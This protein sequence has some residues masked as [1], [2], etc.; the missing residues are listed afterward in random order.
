MDL[1]ALVKHTWVSCKLSA[2]YSLHNFQMFSPLHGKYMAGSA[3]QRV[4]ASRIASIV[5]AQT[6]ATIKCGSKGCTA[7]CHPL[8]CRNGGGYLAAR[9]PAG[10]AAYRGFCPLHGDAARRRDSSVSLP[11]PPAP[12]LQPTGQVLCTQLQPTPVMGRVSPV[13]LAF[14]VVS[15]AHASHP[16][17]ALLCGLRSPV[18]PSA[19]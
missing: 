8:C 18:K 2:R 1:T 5:H 11:P 17:P 15:T 12:Y 9:G 6:G 16:S 14:A 13:R 7:W 4:R 10:G 19:W 3:S